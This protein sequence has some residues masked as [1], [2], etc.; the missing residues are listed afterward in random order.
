[1]GRSNARGSVERW[2]AQQTAH[3]HTLLSPARSPFTV[4]A[5]PG[6]AQVGNLDDTVALSANFVDGANFQRA[7][8]ELR[9]EALQVGLSRY[10]M[11][12]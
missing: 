7:R 6:G 10:N 11:T 2:R 5:F 3:A 4:Y 1:V 9:K 8:R 12:H